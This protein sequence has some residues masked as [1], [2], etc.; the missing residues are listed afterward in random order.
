MYII[1][2]ETCYF[3]SVKVEF[4]GRISNI[5][6]FHSVKVEFFNQDF[7]IYYLLSVKWGDI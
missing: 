7:E 6:Y 2:R 3:H 1:Y 4:F 5:C